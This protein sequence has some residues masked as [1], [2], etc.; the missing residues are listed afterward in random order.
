MESTNPVDFSCLQKLS[1]AFGDE[2]PIDD[3]DKDESTEETASVNF[4]ICTL[5]GVN[6]DAS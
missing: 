5:K 4:H 2:T 3:R 1:W 6:I